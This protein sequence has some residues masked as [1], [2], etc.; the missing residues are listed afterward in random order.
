MSIFIAVLIAMNVPQIFLSVMILPGAKLSWWIQVILAILFCATYA[1]VGYWAYHLLKNAAVTPIFSNF[2]LRN[3]RKVWWLFFMWLLMMA[4]VMVFRMLNMHLTG[5]KTTDNQHAIEMLMSTLSIPMVTM[6]IYGVF[7]AP[8]V[9]EIIFRGLILNYFFRH[10]WWWSNIILSGFL[11]ALPHVFIPTSLATFIDYLMYMSMGM[12]LAY[13]YKRT[14]RLQ[15]NIAVHMLNNG[16]S[17]IPILITLIV[18]T[19]TK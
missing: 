17:M 4:I 18:K 6:V 7:L 2:N 14:G 3:W 12:I 11:F 19:V 10:Q 15:D 1:L 9:E 8:I 5:V 16:I 13:I